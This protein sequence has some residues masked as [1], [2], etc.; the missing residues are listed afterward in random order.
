MSERWQRRLILAAK[1]IATALPLAASLEEFCSVNKNA[2]CSSSTTLRE[3][4]IQ[5][6]PQNFWSS[7][8]SELS[9]VA[10]AQSNSGCTA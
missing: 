5:P 1:L 6:K 9:V 2:V 7:S 10:L 3:Q 8:G 4:C